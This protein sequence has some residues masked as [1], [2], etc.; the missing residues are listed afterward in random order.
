MFLVKLKIF[1]VLFLWQ[2]HFENMRFDHD[3]IF[4]VMQAAFS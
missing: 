2:P 4:N 3:I 1:R